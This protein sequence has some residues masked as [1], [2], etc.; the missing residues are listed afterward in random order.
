MLRLLRALRPFLTL[1]WLFATVFAL[2]FL[3]LGADAWRIVVSERHPSELGC[4]EWSR[5]AARPAWVRLHGC[6]LLAD[7][8][9][10]LE[11]SNRLLPAPVL[12]ALTAANGR[13]V[14]LAY[15]ILPRDFDRDPSRPPGESFEG[16]VY[17]LSK[18]RA[19]A[20]H[21]PRL[22]VLHTDEPVAV[23]LGMSVLPLA[24]WLIAFSRRLRR[25]LHAVDAAERTAARARSMH[26]QPLALID[27]TPLLQLRRSLLVTAPCWLAGLIWLLVVPS[28]STLPLGTVAALALLGGAIFLWDRAR[29]S[30]MALV[31]AIAPLGIIGMGVVALF[32][33]SSVVD[34]LLQS[35]IA[36]YG[37]LATALL[38]RAL[39]RVR[40]DPA[41]ARLLEIERQWRWTRRQMRI[42]LM[43]GKARLRY[44]ALHAL[45]IVLGAAA[46]L[47][48]LVTGIGFA[49][50]AGLAI[51]FALRMRAQRHVLPDAAQAL[52]TDARTPVLYLRSFLDDDVVVHSRSYR[53]DRSISEWV[54]AQFNLIGPV[55]AIAR[56]GERLPPLGPY[57][58][59]LPAHGDWQAE[60]R[61]RLARSAMIVLAF[62]VTPGV[63]WELGELAARQA[64]SRTCFVFPPI[65]SVELDRRWQRLDEHAAAVPALQALGAIDPHRLLMAW[66]HG[67]GTLTVAA[68]TIRRGAA[69]EMAFAAMWLQRGLDAARPAGVAR[70]AA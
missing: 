12:V 68:S 61:A 45:G 46:A 14:P 51:F 62:G 15:V 22:P 29:P 19:R 52:A 39:T 8:R 10:E 28:P 25:N 21:D 69:Y 6:R 44:L 41:R 58:I 35:A 34:V 47:A 31:A 40:G 63:R 67:D 26:P 66:I 7:R 13:G 20:A 50:G 48:L 36:A 70:A 54:A 38:A 33:A 18:D 65:D 56:P 32:G 3:V 23:V 57:R 16:L 4:T 53:R 55:I 43:T 11:R 30:R 42:R 59:E 60:V 1:G 27:I 24:A 5:K 64:L 17:P 9:I 49:I 2:G 37:V